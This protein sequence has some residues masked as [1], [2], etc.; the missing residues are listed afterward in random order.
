M[1]EDL[2]KI[3]Y[4]PAHPAGFGGPSK[5]AKASG[6][7][8]KQVRKWLKGQIAYT[9]NRPVR[10]KFNTRAY[11]VGGINDLWQMDLMEMI[12]YAKINKGY[13]YILTCIDVFSRFA[14]AVPM[15]N[16]TAKETSDAI[17]KMIKKDK[18]FHIQT[19]LGKE[20]YNSTVKQLFKQHG[21]N[22]YSVNSQ[23]K[24]S[25]VERFNRTLRERM[26][27]LF[28]ARGNKKWVGV[29]PSI[30]ESYNHSVHRGIG[31]KP[32]EVTKEN[33]MKI[34]ESQNQTESK[35]KVKYKVG[36]YVRIS[37]VKGPFLKN[38]DQNWS[39]EVFIIDGIDNKKPVM[40]TVKDENNERVSGKFYESELQV[41][42]KPD[43]YR[44]QKI[45]RSKGKGKD[46]QYYVKWHGYKEPTWINANQ[47]I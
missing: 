37:K 42:D 18:P 6:K 9:L 47:I 16:K 21:I 34:W 1:E 22:H 40:Y 28:T 31:M 29:L 30:I 8:L 41:I 3:W 2:K 5:L 27:K 44:I 7:T 36:D 10:R 43:V 15:Q 26:N 24:A 38:F 14:R 35:S 45:I 39:D 25:L 13:K 4:D 32:V 19:D 12:P 20:F 17:S 33:E 46:K 11:R 23:F